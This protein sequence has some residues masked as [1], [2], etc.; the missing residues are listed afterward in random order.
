KGTRVAWTRGLGLPFDPAVTTAVDA[1]RRTFESLGCVVEDAEPDFSDADEVFKTWR[2]RRFDTGLGEEVEEHRDKLK[3][4]VIWNI[5]EGARL[6]G[7][8][9]GRAEVKRTQL[10][11]RVRTFM[12]RYEFFV[13]PTSQVPPFDVKQPYVNQVNGVPMAT[14]VDWMKSC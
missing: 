5:E 1:Q 7:P 12:E 3:D 11:H 9:L 8:Q 4:T 2:A 14:Y 6:T 13:L 10:Y